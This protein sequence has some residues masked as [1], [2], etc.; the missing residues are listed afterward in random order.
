MTY[1][2]SVDFV[3]ELKENTEAGTCKDSMRRF[4]KEVIV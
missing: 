4:G 3:V 1:G 2:I